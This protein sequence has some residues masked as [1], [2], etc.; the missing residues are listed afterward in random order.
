MSAAIQFGREVCGNLEAAEA[1]EWLVTNGIGGYASGT[2][3]GGI[4]RRYH[5]LLVAALQPPVGRV[6]LVAALD[7]IV[8]Y[9]SAEFALATHRWVGDAVEPKGFQYIEGFRL[10][11]ATPVWTYALG[12][13]RLE[14]RAW[15]QQG[16]NT[17]YVQYRFVQG[18]APIEMELKALVNYRDFHAWWKMASESWRSTGPRRFI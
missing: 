18:S 16:T 17:T 7:E 15:M 8:R 5:G 11:G 6:H 4:T 10:D 12:D 14:K 9:G 1:R 13:A 3:A 2:I